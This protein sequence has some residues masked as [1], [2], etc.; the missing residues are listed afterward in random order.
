VAKTQA[1]PRPTP[2]VPAAPTRERIVRASADLFR[3]R[4]YAGTGL[5]AIL[6]D[7]NAPYGSL[8]HF[9]PG[10]K[11]ELGA[12]ALRAGGETYRELVDTIFAEGTD[13]V[14]ATREFFRGAASVLEQTDYA[15]ACPIATMASEIASS[16]ETMRVAASEVFESWLALLQQRFEAAGMRS[17]RAR[18]VAVQCFCLVEGAFFLSRAN[19][20]TEPLAAAGRAAV[21]AVQSALDG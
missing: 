19:R 15:D 11:E 2:P 4:G 12:A 6:A 7:S 10:G 18:R 14:E 13:V 3:R 1:N 16:S 20:D 8:Y 5:K 9:F 21:A 17:K